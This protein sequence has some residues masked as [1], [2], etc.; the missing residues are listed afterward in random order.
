MMSSF[1]KGE[2][3]TRPWGTSEHDVFRRQ[4]RWQV[5]LSPFFINLP[6]FQIVAVYFSASTID[7]LSFMPSWLATKPR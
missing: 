2:P 4:A 7:R 1:V 6:Q 5:T 3:G